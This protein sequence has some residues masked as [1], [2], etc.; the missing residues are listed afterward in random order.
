M[1]PCLL[2]DDGQQGVTN[3]PILRAPGP[4]KPC[5]KR[6][7]SSFIGKKY[8]E[9]PYFVTQTDFPVVKDVN[10]PWKNMENIWKNMVKS[11]SLMVK[12]G[13]NH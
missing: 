13:Q 5:A 2:G 8:G 3:S 9:N 6:V 7:W 10:L 1:M 4:R 11:S 12:S